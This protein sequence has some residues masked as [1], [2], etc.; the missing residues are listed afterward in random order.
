MLH[1]TRQ[2]ISK[3]ENGRGYP[4]L[5]NLIQLSKVY[6]MSIDNLLSENPNLKKQFNLSDEQIIQ[7]QSQSKKINTDLYQ[8]TD[9]GIIL[10]IL[11][12]V[13]GLIPPIGIFMPLYVAWRNNKYNSLYK[14]INLICIIVLLISILGTYVIIVDNWLI[15][16]RTTIYQIK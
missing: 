10:I 1:V 9:E 15:P 11:S 4:D 2:S 14:T 13:S 3:W 8:N 16:A 12:I 5:D 7:K 6:K